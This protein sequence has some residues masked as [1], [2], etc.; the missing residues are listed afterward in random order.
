MT[1]GLDGAD[2]PRPGPLV[3]PRDGKRKP[4]ANSRSDSTGG[5]LLDPGWMGFNVEHTW[6]PLGPVTGVDEQLPDSLR[7][8]SDLV[9]DHDSG[10]LRRFRKR[11]GG[12]ES[13]PPAG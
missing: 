6:P 11:E 2:S 5:P 12:P 4:G 9:P 13:I 10:P 3:D 7:R 1:S 8:R